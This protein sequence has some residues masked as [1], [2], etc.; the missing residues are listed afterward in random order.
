MEMDS[1]GGGE[2]NTGKKRGGKK[3]KTH[4]GKSDSSQLSRKLGKDDP[5]ISPHAG[6]MEREY[7]IPHIG[8]DDIRRKS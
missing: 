6:R 2:K 1:G 8:G 7:K 4:N 3:A 5:F